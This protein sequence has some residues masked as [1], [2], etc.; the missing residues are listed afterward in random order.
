MH[1]QLQ[2][3]LKTLQTSVTI[4][5]GIQPTS[6]VTMAMKVLRNTCNMCIHDMSDM[7]PSFLRSAALE[8]WAY[9]TGKSPMAHVTTNSYLTNSW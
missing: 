1:N 6:V 5:C 8:L 2:F 4:T 7:M 3:A 9:V